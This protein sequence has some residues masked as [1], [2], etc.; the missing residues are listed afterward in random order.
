MKGSASSAMVA[1]EA[2]EAKAAALEREIEEL[3]AQ[4]EKSEAERIRCIYKTFGPLQK[5]SKMSKTTM[6]GWVF[7]ISF[8]V[9][10]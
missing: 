7:R 5:T 10:F 9:Y 1:K 3:E 6:N 4:R 2:A 8:V